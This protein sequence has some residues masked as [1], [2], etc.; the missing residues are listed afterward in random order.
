MFT[1][2]K[3][4]QLNKSNKHVLRGFFTMKVSILG[5]GGLTGRELIGLLRDHPEFEIAHI[6]SNKEVGKSIQDVFPNLN[7]KSNLKF[8]SHQDEVPKDSLV[9]LAVPNEVSLEKAPK[10]LDKGHKVID[11]SGAYRLHDK[12]KFETYYGLKHESFHLMDKVVFG[13]TEMNRGKLKNADFVSNPGCFATSS[14]LPIFM[15]GELRNSISNPIVI[16]A[17]S[18]VSGAGG[19]TEDVGFTFTNTYENFRAYKILSHQHTPEIQE[20]VSIGIPSMPRIVFTPHLL[21]VYRGILSTFVIQFNS[22][23]LAQKV[24]EN[25]SKFASE[26]FIRVL[27]KPEEVELKNVQNS[28]YIDIGFRTDD[29]ILVIVSAL[30]NLVKGAAGQALQNMNLMCGFSETMGLLKEK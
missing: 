13:L 12:V 11:I 20:Y 24:A 28:N 2:N 15:L 30:D 29:N 7:L 16:D 14:I 4:D 25:F 19:R 23:D 26:P 5:A 18:G 27:P 3:V 9:V 6:T 22:S 10:F 1:K 17:K 21:P 8:K